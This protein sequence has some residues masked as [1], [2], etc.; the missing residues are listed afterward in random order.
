MNPTWSIVICTHNRC[1]DLRETLEGLAGLDYPA[2][3]FEIIVVDNASQDDTPGVVEAAKARLADLISLQEERLGL[4]HARNTGIARARGE[5]I[6]FLDDD[7]APQPDWLQK[8]ER[9]FTDPRVACV[10][11]RVM[12]VWQKLAGWPDW[13]H[14]RL[15]GYFTVI[16][17]PKFRQLRYPFCPAG[18]N[19]AFR[20]TVFAEVGT[21]NPRL[22]RTGDSLLSGEEADLCVAIDQA[23]YRIVYTPEA[24]VRHRVHENR[25]TREW[26][27]QR[28]HWGG[29]SSAIIEGRRFGVVNRVLKS[30]KNCILIIASELLTRLFRLVPNRKEALFWECQALFS[31]AFLKNLWINHPTG[32]E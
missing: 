30:G 29:V 18:T 26:V 13:L 15:I 14:N 8:L 20:K 9:C 10:G 5:F 16:D 25:L 12:P 3:K 11:G 17:Y 27:L 19:V 22:G 32:D 1:H 31:R 6:A 21:F 4:S 7:A 23:G 24:V 28:S 2:G